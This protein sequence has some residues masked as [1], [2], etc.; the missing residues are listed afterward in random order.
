VRPH[1][2]TRAPIRDDRR[3]I[4]DATT[5]P[6]ADDLVTQSATVT[7]VLSSANSA[8]ITTGTM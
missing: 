5:A 1:E 8:A 3:D 2:N 7:K 4:S 6:A